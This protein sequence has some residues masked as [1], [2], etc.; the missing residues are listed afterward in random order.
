MN[1]SEIVGLFHDRNGSAPAEAETKYGSY[2]LYIARN[3][4]GDEGDAEEC[5]NDALLAA[6]ESIPPQR[7]ENLKAYLGKLTREAAIDR[8]RFNNAQKRRPGSLAS[9]E[10]LANVVPGCDPES[11]IA[12]LELAE[13]ISEFLRSEGET[14]RNVFIRRYWYYDTIDAICAGY[15]L[16]RRRVKTMLKRSRE[17]LA[18]HLKKEGYNEYI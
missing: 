17:R 16:G 1:D 5:L 7:P 8:L 3:L 9:L 10:E 18:A 2:C 13:H 6:W 12:R 11:S 14:E 4:L 15:G